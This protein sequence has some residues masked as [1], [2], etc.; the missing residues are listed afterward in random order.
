MSKILSAL[1][2]ATALLAGEPRRIY[3]APDD[4]TDYLWSADEE[5]YR[6]AFVEMLD[7][8]LDLADATASLPPEHRSRWNCD[9]SIWLHA[10]ER[11]KPR[12]DFERLIARIR[13]G[14]IS[15]PLNTLVA[16]YGA[17]PAEA[18]LRGMFYAG[19]LERRYGLR[20]PIAVAMEDQTLPYGLGALWA[21][22][23]AKYS[24]KGICGCLTKLKKNERRPHEIYWWR[25]PD[26]SRILMKWYTLLG[27]NKS[28]G[29]YAEA[30][31]PA[32][33]I[34]FVRTSEAFS[35][36]HPYPVIGLFG[37]GWDRLKTLDDEFVRAARAK[38]S[39]DD[40]VIVSNQVDFFEDFE[41]SHGESLPE[42]SAAFGNEWDLYSAS[43]AEVSSRV[44]RAVEKL[45]AAEALAVLVALESPEFLAGR[46]DERD[47]A[48]RALGLYWEHNWTA[49]GPVV[50]RE[51]R[52]AWQR[53]V[54][55]DVESYV[56]RLHAD[57]A[58][59]FGGLIAGGG[60][61]E[62]FFVFNPLSWSRTDAADL[63]YDGPEPAHVVD[64]VTGAETPSQFIGIE[65]QGF[66]KPQRLL[67]VL[68]PDVPAVGYKVF[69]VRP[70]P[71]QSFPATVSAEGNVAENEFYR[72]RLEGRGA[73][74]SLVDK[75]RDGREL[76][77]LKG[78]AIN[79]LGPGGG[80]VDVEN[81][82]LV[83]VT[84]VAR[85]ASPV[86][87]ATRVTL[88][89]SVSRVDIE[90]EITRNFG[91]TLAWDFG[92]NL[93]SPDVWHEE[94]GA[95]IRA[96]LLAAGG[97]YSPTNSRL[98]WLTLNH[99]ADMSGAGGA[100]I[101]LSNRDC[102]FMRLGDS[103]TAGGVSRL[104]TNTPRISVLAGGQI[105][106]PQAGIPR[107]GGD[108]RFLQRF[109][110]RT[111]GGFH[112]P[113]A[114]RFALEHQNP[115]VAGRVR[116]KGPYP[117]ASWSALTISDPDTLLWSLKPAEEGIAD[118]V[119]VRLW[120]LGAQEK[121]VALAP[122]FPLGRARRATHI[123]TDAEEIPVHDSRASAV[124]RGA[125][126]LTVRLLRK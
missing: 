94:V 42:F 54:A 85:G 61:R 98:D 101:T 3:I 6:Q 46:D 41:K 84:L 44:R 49:D 1:L 43:L 79:D 51:G 88:Y 114:M 97:H 120:N 75:T 32:A 93:T 125:Q 5:T 122:S 27:E 18:V 71:G 102:A 26:G 9:G 25:G 82:G 19:R 86:E 52:A 107:Q 23:G 7:H 22:A 8:Y 110:L 57:A 112:A 89:R 63:P 81:A 119:I 2:L 91:E 70:G 80:A 118:G 105:D 58:F 83:S 60:S 109:A 65:A 73:L 17:A 20:F 13:D 21:G 47:R 106:A 39:P 90:N 10:Y 72:L 29:G 123:E 31:D 15:A 4:H 33:S 74:S 67:R 108:D 96:K 87:H 48:W 121:T 117:E 103:A 36:I 62:R 76:S 55:G 45:R 64:L 37:Q 30:F 16:C 12:A 78:P 104:D 113:A 40:S 111:H 95:V 99:F 11:S 77:A 56:D 38:S 124:I 100:G 28:V 92:F 53:R 59:S 14:H 34:D 24:W 126:M 66:H 115:L 116:G 35:A 68:A 50:T 69:E